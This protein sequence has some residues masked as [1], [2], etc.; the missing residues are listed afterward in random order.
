[1]TCRPTLRRSRMPN[2]VPSSSTDWVNA[3]VHYLD[4]NGQEVDQLRPSIG[5]AGPGISTWA[6]D[7]NG[8]VVKELASQ[9]SRAW[10]FCVRHARNDRALAGDHPPLQRQSAR[11]GVAA[12]PRHKMTVPAALARSIVDTKPP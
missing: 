4:V 11:R 5:S 8:N 12:R 10:R 3:T 7:V 9:Q 6:Y 2:H 1:M